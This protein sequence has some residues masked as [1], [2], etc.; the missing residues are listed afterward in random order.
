M[1]QPMD[2]A[3]RPAQRGLILDFAGVLT[4]DPRPV[5]RAWCEAEGLEPGAWRATLND[6]PEGRRLYV[7]LEIG[8]IDQAAWNEGTAALLGP[9]VE[10]TNL[11]GRAWSGVPAAQRMIGLARAARAAGY[12]LALLSN[13]FGMDPFNPYEHSGIWDLFD[14]HVISEAVGLAKP[15]PAIYQLVLD[16]LG[17]P[18]PACVFVDDHPVNLPPAEALGITTVLAQD[19]AAAV[20]ELEEMLGVNAVLRVQRLVPAVVQLPSRG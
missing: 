4:A 6:N 1:P 17:L 10:P 19:E 3:H 15:D 18:G 14:V 8:Q 13:S 20:A 11:M 7:A 2:T 16:R 12:R 9:H 5:H